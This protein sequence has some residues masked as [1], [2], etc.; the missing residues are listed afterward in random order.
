MYFK[1]MPYWIKNLFLIFL[2]A[3]TASCNL[4]VEP[5]EEEI[6]LVYLTE[7]KSVGTYMLPLAQFA[8]QQLETAL[9]GI[10]KLS[11]QA[12]Y[13]VSVY[14]IQYKT[15]YKGNEVEASGIVAIPAAGAQ[16]KLPLLSFQNG[17]NTLA[18]RAPSLNSSDQG[19]IVLQMLASLGYIVIIP[20]YLG[21]G[22]SAQLPHPYLH[23]SSTVESITDMYRAV[24][25]LVSAGELNKKLNGDLF[26]TGY[27]QGGWA[28]LAL[29][30][31]LEKNP[32]SGLSLKGTAAGSGPYSLL[33]FTSYLIDLQQYNSP[34][35]LGYLFHSLIETQSVAV[36]YTDI[37]N[38]PYAAIIPT[39]YDGTRDEGYINSQLTNSIAELFSAD[40]RSK[41][42]TDAKYTAVRSAMASNTIP[43]WKITTPLF[44]RHGETDTTVPII[45]STTLKDELNAA[46]APPSLINYQVYPGLNHGDAALPFIAS[47][48]E[49]I[50][51]LP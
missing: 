15:R 8:F 40:F 35:Y 19:M 39:L 42:L 2:L 25:E 7:Y 1:A 18:S 45:M 49:W 22:A 28:S 6:P 26:L 20:D 36:S 37:F 4:F 41:L 9:P 32:V 27:S 50:Q 43:G 17:T 5:E 16:D 24:K 51:S 48:V 12:K 46:G 44:L 31:A 23:K 34:A 29:M 14:A 13:G 11:T 47:A 3:F 21:F 30:E 10:P 38:A 33:S